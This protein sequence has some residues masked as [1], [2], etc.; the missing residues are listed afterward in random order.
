MRRRPTWCPVHGPDVDVDDDGDCLDTRGMV[1]GARCGWHATG[2][3]AAAAHRAHDRVAEM[4]ARLRVVVFPS[5][6]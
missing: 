1:E 6:S 5:L 2:D 4:E 3:G